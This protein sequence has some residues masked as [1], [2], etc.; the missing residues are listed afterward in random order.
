MNQ[1]ITKNRRSFVKKFGSMA[2]MLAMSPSLSTLANELNFSVPSLSPD[3]DATT[4][5][6]YWG[7]VQQAYSVSPNVINLNNGG[8]SPQP[9]VVQDALDRYNRLSNEAP[10]YYMWRTLDE[11]RESLRIKLADLAGCSPEEIAINRNSS[12]ALETVIFG[13]NLQKGDEVV[14]TKQDYPNMINAWRQREKREGIVLKFINLD[15]PI[16]DNKLIV[17]IYKEAFT[18]NTKVVMITHLI[19]WS[20]QIMPA[21]LISQAAKKHN[22]NID[23][24]IDAAHSFAHI[25]YKIPELGG[26]YLGTSLH[27]WLSAP[28]GTGMLYIRKEKIKN[29]WPMF[30]AN[31]PQSSDIRKFE[32]LGT[33]SFP[34]EMATGHAV[35]FHNAIG[36]DRKEKR[37]HYLKNYW[38]EKC[39]NIPGFSTQ[40]SLKPEFSG[41]IATFLIKGMAP[42]QIGSELFKRSRIHTTSVEWE[43]IKGV[44]VTPHVYTPLKDLDRLVDTI[45]AIAKEQ[46]SNTSMN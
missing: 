36:S 30:A 31:A 16:E 23:V 44:R 35:N 5:E 37:L 17:N 22:P 4:N 39:L 38:M 12:E 29:I 40:T 6:D 19:N 10:S 27:K 7:W 34:T 33:R 24:V 14:L 45:H 1:N 32:S 15:L 25:N 20:G 46:P 21:A 18:S 26:D 43:N 28:F 42:G 8:V 11:G 41:A 9:I 3:E 2:G 13:L